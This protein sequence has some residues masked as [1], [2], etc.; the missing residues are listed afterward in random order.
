MAFASG[1][2]DPALFGEDSG[3]F[4][5]DR[6]DAEL[7]LAFGKGPHLCLGAPLGRLETKIALELLTTMVPDMELVPGASIEYSPNAL[8]RGLKALTVAP[9][10]VAY[11]EEVGALPVAP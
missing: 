3:E 9:S 2:H 8:F 10:G 7:H 6:S 1:D 4:E 11:A 5:V